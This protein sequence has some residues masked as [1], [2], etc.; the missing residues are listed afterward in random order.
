MSAI[1]F[2][3]FPPSIHS[4]NLL[5]VTQLIDSRMTCMPSFSEA[6]VKPVHFQVVQDKREIHLSYV[7][8][9]CMYKR[10]ISLL[11]CFSI[12]F[13]YSLSCFCILSYPISAI[14]NRHLVQGLISHVKSPYLKPEC[15]DLIPDLTADSSLSK[16]LAWKAAVMV[17][18]VESLPLTRGTWIDSLTPGFSSAQHQLQRECRGKEPTIHLHFSFSLCFLNQ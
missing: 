16:V 14:G 6:Q 7:F 3:S 15:L 12:L 13:L 2:L 17:P 18:V 1:S 8:L 9:L 4:M 10:C 5:T 11:S